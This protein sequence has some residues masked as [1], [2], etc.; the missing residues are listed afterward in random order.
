MNAI[1][2]DDKE[3]LKCFLPEEKLFYAYLLTNENSNI[4]G[5]YCFNKKKAIKELGFSEKT[6]THLIE[7]L[8][9]YEIIRYDEETGEVYVCNYYKYFWKCEEI[10]FLA[11][12]EIEKKVASEVFKEELIK[13]VNQF[14]AKEINQTETGNQ[15]AKKQKENKVEKVTNLTKEVINY[16]NEKCGMKYRC[17][18]GYI[19][20]L[21]K[22]RYNDGFTDISDYKTVID[23][24]CQQ[25]LG[26]D[27]EKYLRPDT[28]FGVKFEVYLNEMSK[29]YNNK[30]KRESSCNGERE[31]EQSINL[32][33]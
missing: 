6:I 28:L 22:A 5:C 29:E 13:L 30:Q 19:A 10:V 24:K 32:W 18:S 16:L 25:W 4:C 14:I 2:W 21:I 23:K 20:R 26:T 31:L 1:T 33:D 8:S 27:L 12:E 9:G 7:L 3:F 15:K 11:R 17:N